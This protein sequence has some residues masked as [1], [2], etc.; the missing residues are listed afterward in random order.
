MRKLASLAALIGLVVAIQFSFQKFGC[1]STETKL[2][3]MRE[4]EDM[5]KR[6][7]GLSS[8]SGSSSGATDAGVQRRRRARDAHFLEGTW[9]GIVSEEARSYDARLTFAKTADGIVGTSEYP[10]FP[11]RGDLGSYHISGD[12]YRFVE[13]IADGSEFCANGKLEIISTSP[14]RFMWKWIRVGDKDH[15]A[16]G[17]FHRVGSD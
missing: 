1:G 7:D 16:T 3:Q 6:D 5:A 11:C 14:D 9:T 17:D 12:V 2:E 4:E 10:S 13:T 8:T 15:T